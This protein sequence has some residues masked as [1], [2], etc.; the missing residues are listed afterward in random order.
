MDKELQRKI[1]D[2]QKKYKAMGDLKKGKPL[3][4][5]LLRKFCLPKPVFAPPEERK[6]NEPEE[7]DEEANIGDTTS[8]ST[9]LNDPSELEDN[10]H[11]L[12]TLK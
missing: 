3:T 8:V 12:L 7:E 10:P 4:L 1:M 2:I 11:A 6:G 9:H 5:S